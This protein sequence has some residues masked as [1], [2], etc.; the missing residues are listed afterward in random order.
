MNFPQSKPRTP[1]CVKVGEHKD[2]S[3]LETRSGG[4][5]EDTKL[6][7]SSCFRLFQ[8]PLSRSTAFIYHGSVSSLVREGWHG[9]YLFLSI[10]ASARHVISSCLLSE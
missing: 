8:L 2:G 5:S 3:F 4:D 9:D 7:M 6:K 10:P 1:G